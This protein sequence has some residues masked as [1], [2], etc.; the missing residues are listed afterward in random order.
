MKAIIL[1]AG[2]GVRMNP[3]SSNKP[4]C[5]F[6]L[7]GE[8]AILRQLRLLNDAGV[9]DIVAVVGFEAEQI[10]KAVGDKIRFIQN[11][12]FRCTSSIY[13]L[14]K[15]RRK[16]DDDLLV[17][18]SDIV[19]TKSFLEKMLRTLK[20]RVPICLPI[21]S[22]KPFEEIDVGVQIKGGK[23]VRVGK[24]MPKELCHAGSVDGF[25][26]A[27]EGCGRLKDAM[28]DMLMTSSAE[29]GI[30]SL[31][32]YLAT[33]TPLD[34]KDVGNNCMDFDTIEEYQKVRELFG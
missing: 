25:S 31:K 4:K 26:V 6:E 11:P 19:Y 15:A 27:R 28:M 33:G 5:L 14:W 2:K 12:R 29:G 1:A 17:L 20:E 13:S 21:N 22:K 16:L 10:K 32:N 8:L 23:V 34:F 3:L 24:N 30:Y 9:K 7:R 18:N